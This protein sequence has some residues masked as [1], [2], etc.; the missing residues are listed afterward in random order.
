L[1]GF[2]EENERRRFFKRWFKKIKKKL[3]ANPAQ[4]KAKL[5][6]VINGIKRSIKRHNR[7]LRAYR[8][9]ASRARNYF[10]RKFWRFK[11]IYTRRSR[12]RRITALKQAK[13]AHGKIKTGR[14]RFLGSWI[15]KIKKRFSPAKLKKKLTNTI[16][17][18]KRRIPNLRKR[19]RDFRRRARK[20]RGYWA[21]RYHNAKA[22]YY[23]STIRRMKRG[24]NKAR[25]ALKRAG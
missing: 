2:V 25:K 8:R 17:Y 10:A 13:A 23:R 15:R 19:M 6:R 21:K 4:L 5:G 9:A 24:L 3:G 7:K 11:Y 12:N 18:I 14:R 20:A 22:N 1:A 16:N